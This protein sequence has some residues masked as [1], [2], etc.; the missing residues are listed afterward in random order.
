MLSISEIIGKFVKNSSQRD[1]DKLKPIV[2]QINE[3][4]SIIKQIPDENFPLK[5]L[6]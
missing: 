1:I 4:E 5:T 3:W 2:K 6:D